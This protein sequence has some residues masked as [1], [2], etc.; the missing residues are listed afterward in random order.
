MKTNACCKLTHAVTGVSV[1]IR[2]V[3]ITALVCLDT[4]AM[5]SIALV[6]ITFPCFPSFHAIIQC[7]PNVK[8]WRAK[9]ES[10][11]IINVMLIYWMVISSLLGSVSIMIKAQC[12][13]WLLSCAVAGG[14]A[15]Q[16]I[17]IPPNM[18]MYTLNRGDHTCRLLK[19]ERLSVR[20]QN[21]AARSHLMYLSVCL[22]IYLSQ[23]HIPQGLMGF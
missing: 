22:S 21:S 14:G 9:R 13:A 10:L 23:S 2:S 18:Y 4:V 11:E 16:G 8:L 15:T 6:T 19:A 20:H 7:L 3:V 12:H 1:R 5:E 17:W